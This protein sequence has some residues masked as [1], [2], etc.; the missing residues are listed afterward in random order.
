VIIDLPQ[1]VDAAANNNAFRMLARDV[2]NMNDYC[3]RFAPELRAT[4][5]AYE[6]WYLF[7]RGELRADT[8]L[9]GRF[10]HDTRQA[11]VGS[12]L[13]QIEEARREAEIR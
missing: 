3:G 12:V 9:T 10:E 7:E 4:E 11:D 6:I 1:A 5:Y 2:G 13:H 8:V